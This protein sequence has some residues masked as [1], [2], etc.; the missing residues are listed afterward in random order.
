[1]YSSL[2]DQ[3]GQ[4]KLILEYSPYT[5]GQLTLTPLVTRGRYLNGHKS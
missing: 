1:M 4:S 3:W 5:A 2:K